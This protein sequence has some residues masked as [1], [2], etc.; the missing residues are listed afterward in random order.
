MGYQV[1]R[2][3]NGARPGRFEV[4]RSVDGV[5]LGASRTFAAFRSYVAASIFPPGGLRRTD[6]G[7]PSS[8]SVQPVAAA[9]FV[10]PQRALLALTPPGS[11]ATTARSRP[12][13]SA[14]AIQRRTSAP[15][16]PPACR[17]R[18]TSAVSRPAVVNIAPLLH[19][20]TKEH[21][22]RPLDH[23]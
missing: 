9:T 18:R 1:H 2:L 19:F 17:A 11:A 14:L 13:R 20:A 3:S 23:A 4:G 22:Q 15:G 10:Y 6:S 8:A 21:P 7:V 5:A 12:A 16:L